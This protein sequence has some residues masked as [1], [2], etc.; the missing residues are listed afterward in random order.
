MNSFLKNIFISNWQKDFIIDGLCEKTFTYK[1]FWSVVLNYQ[2]YLKNLGL[3]KGD[4]ICLLMSNSFE[5]VAIYFASLL[6]NLTV[7]PID[8]LRGVLEIETMVGLSGCKKVVCDSDRY[9]FSVEII[10]LEDMKINFNELLSVEIDCLDVLDDVDFDFLYLITF[11]SGSTGIPKG[12]MHSFNNLCK[13][14][15]SFNKFFNFNDENIFYHNLPMCYMAGILNLIILPLLSGSK[16]V[17][18]HRFDFSKVL[19]FWNIPKKYSVNTFWFIPTVLSLLLRLDRGSSGIDYFHKVQPIGC[20][21]TA[22]LSGT[23]KKAFEKKYNIKLYES[24]GLSETL[25]VSTNSPLV[26]DK[27]NIVGKLLD[28]VKLSLDKNEEILIST[29]WMFLGYLGS[30]RDAFFRSGD[31][32]FLDADNFLAIK[33]R[34][35]NLVIRGGVNI[36]PL[37]IE[38]FIETLDVCR[39]CAILGLKDEILG[40]KIAC[41]FV[42][43]EK[44][45]RDIK[46]ELSSRIHNELGRDYCIDNFFEIDSLPKNVNGKIDRLCLI[47]KYKQV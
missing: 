42:P 21:G 20:V 6:L 4:R 30:K 17:L 24:Y 43:K 31:L 10:N 9:N 23:L 28:G 18:G 27:E 32:G 3:Q 39:E 22:P 19:N 35:K 38:K 16:I 8:P 14:A 36:S 40:E 34:I 15:L 12:V 44:S 5:F 45:N 26:G 37:R 25:F 1:D 2:K 29:D 7:V 13:S 47:N 41:F 46:K 11:T 33:D